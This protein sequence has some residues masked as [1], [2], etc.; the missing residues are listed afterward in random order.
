MLSTFSV[1]NTWL[2]KL[3]SDLASGA[4]TETQTVI[5]Y[6]NFLN[7]IPDDADYEDVNWLEYPS[8]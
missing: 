2:D 1:K 4:L 8:A 3:K 7:N 5:D 6:R